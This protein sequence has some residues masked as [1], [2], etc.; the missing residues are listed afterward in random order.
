MNVKMKKTLGAAA[1]VLAAAAFTADAHDGRRFE[2]KVVDG[3]LVAHG[4]NSAGVDD[5]AGV[6]RPYYNA[7]HDHWTFLVGVNAS[8]SDLPG[9][10]VLVPGELE[11]HSITLTFNGATRWSDVPMM[12]AP[13]TVPL[14]EPLDPGHTLFVSFDGQTVSTDAPGSMML[15]SSV[16]S[17]GAL[18]L[19]LSFDF[20]DQLPATIMVME[21]VLS[22]DAPGVADS[23][24]VYLLLSPDGA[25][26][27]EKR[28]H[29][30]LYLENFLGTPIAEPCIGDI[31]D[32]IG[33]LGSP[34]GE[35]SFGDFL[36]M[37]TLLG[38][39]HHGHGCT[40][41]IADDFGVL[42]MGDGQVSFGDF[43][44]MLSLLGPCP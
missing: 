6:V 34:D 14:L 27:M 8:T 17:G 18:D 10:D 13:G 32:D 33:T 5:G 11:G 37:L 4:Y 20:N 36:A 39:C 7:L 19:D 22:T 31:A 43:L 24:T 3:Q 44:A 15:V 25:N 41:D 2:I 1:A 35:V 16:S 40:G 23:D 30:S 28:H 26:G 21:F 42:G 9:F 38:P 12:P 29:A